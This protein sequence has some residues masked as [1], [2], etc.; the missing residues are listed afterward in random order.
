MIPREHRIT[1]NYKCL[2]CLKRSEPIFTPLSNFLCNTERKNYIKDSRITLFKSNSEYWIKKPAF[3]D[4][5]SKAKSKTLYVYQNK[6]VMFRDVTNRFF[7]KPNEHETS[8]QS[9]EL[10]RASW[11]CPWAYTSIMLAYM[12]IYEH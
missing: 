5:K 12:S 11:F 4:F 7:H 2:K 8:K 3:V 9:H 10:S 6:K 1:N